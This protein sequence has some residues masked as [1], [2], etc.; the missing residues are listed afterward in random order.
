MSKEQTNGEKMRDNWN[1][2]ARITQQPYHSPCDK[3][4]LSY[5]IAVQ[6]YIALA[7]KLPDDYIPPRKGSFWTPKKKRTESLSTSESDRNPHMHR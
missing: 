5:R 2:I 1:R 3:A 4:E 6:N 7:H